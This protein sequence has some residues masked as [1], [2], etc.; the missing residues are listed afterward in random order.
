MDSG[1]RRNEGVAGR[2]WLAY[3]G[4]DS[5]VRGNDGGGAGNDGGGW[6]G[7]AGGA[8]RVRRRC[9]HC[10]DLTGLRVK[11]IRE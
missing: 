11:S 1:F 4:S 9:N 6:P 3:C 10:T 8:V 5:R 2:G 7:A